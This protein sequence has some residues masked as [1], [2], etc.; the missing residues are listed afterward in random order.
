MQLCSWVWESAFIALCVAKCVRH[1]ITA[2]QFVAIYARILYPDVIYTFTVTVSVLSLSRSLVLILCV[3]VNSLFLGVCAR[4]MI[5][6]KSNYADNI[7]IEYSIFCYLLLK[8]QI[9]IRITV[10]HAFA[11][12]CAC[13]VLV[14]HF[15][16]STGEKN[17]DDKHW[18]L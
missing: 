9:I 12:A 14:E 4:H 16:S 17:V 8:Y 7:C 6:F 13:S 10:L 1:Y 3:A 2:R 5:R 15:T 11:F 18:A